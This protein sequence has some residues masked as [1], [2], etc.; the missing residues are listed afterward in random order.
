M[1]ARRSV[2]LVVVV[3]MHHAVGELSGKHLALFRTVHDEAAGGF[4]MIVTCKECVADGLQ[5]A[6]GVA[7]KHAHI[8]LRHLVS[9]CHVPCRI[10]VYQQLLSRQSLPYRPLVVLRRGV[11]TLFCCLCR[12][13][14][15][16]N[17]EQP[18]L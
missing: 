10:Q 3:M 12:S 4:W 1:C 7:V 5:V 13:V 17:A 9:P 18:S 11:L 15:L 8:V 14:Y 16:V 6:V 2:C